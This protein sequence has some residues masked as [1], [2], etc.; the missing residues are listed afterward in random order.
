[1]PTACDR[2]YARPSEAQQADTQDAATDRYPEQAQEILKTA[3]GWSARQTNYRK[4]VRLHS[5][6]SLRPILKR[7]QPSPA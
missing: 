2:R 7:D 1:M 5:F 6:V 3:T 4:A